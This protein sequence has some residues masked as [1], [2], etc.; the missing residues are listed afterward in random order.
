[1]ILGGD[2]NDTI[3]GGAGNDF[4]VGGD[5]N[6]RIVGSAGHDIL[7]AGDIGCGLDLAAL[8]AVSQAWAA[9]RTVT[10]EAVDDFLDETFV[11]D[12]TAI[13]SPAAPAPT[14][15]S[16]TPATRSPTSSSASPTP[17]RT[18]MW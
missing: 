11:N 13:N 17:T 9:S 18:A 5:G 15:S 8:R 3:T 2:G 10:A 6:D 12:Q 16:S 14:C 7:V 1:M 4:L